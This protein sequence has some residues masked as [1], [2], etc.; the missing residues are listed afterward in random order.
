MPGTDMAGQCII[1]Q[2]S[3]LQ[4]WYYLCQRWMSSCS[5]TSKFGLC[6]SFQP[7]SLQLAYSMHLNAGMLS[8]LI[9]GVDRGMRKGSPG[10]AVFSSPPIRLHRP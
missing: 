1:T 10:F 6:R 4:A 8:K 9:P 7:F 3:F 2:L 5:Y